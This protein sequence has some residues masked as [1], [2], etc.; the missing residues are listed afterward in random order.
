[1]KDYIF[2]PVAVE[3]FGSRG[4]IGLNFIKYIGRKI[5]EKTGQKIATCH[6]IQAISM[7]IQRGN[8]PQQK[9]EEYFDILMPIVEKF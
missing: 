3:T 9:L 5:R 7:R 4:P 2:V 1:M 8:G 6:I